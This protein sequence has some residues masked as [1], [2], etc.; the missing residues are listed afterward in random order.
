MAGVDDTLAREAFKLAQ[1]KLPFKTKIVT[2][3]GENELF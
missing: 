1:S 2:K 3:E